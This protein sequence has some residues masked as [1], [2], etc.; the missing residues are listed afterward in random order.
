MVDRVIEPGSFEE[1]WSRVAEIDR[2]TAHGEEQPISCY[3]SD[4]CSCARATTF[5]VSC[6]ARSMISIDFIAPS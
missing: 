1:T 2:S 3:P 4:A 6:A 5:S